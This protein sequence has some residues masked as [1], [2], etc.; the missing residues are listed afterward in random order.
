MAV[1]SYAVYLFHNSYYVLLDQWLSRYVYAGG[2]LKSAIFLSVGVLVLFVVAY[3]LQRA[4]DV[5][6]NPLFRGRVMGILRNTCQKH[7]PM[8]KTGEG[9]GRRRG[10]R[11][12]IPSPAGLFTPA[13]GHSRRLW[14]GSGHGRCRTPPR[15]RG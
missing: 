10:G 13:P 14:P 3:S 5:I 7:N 9:H 11:R 15:G 4:M 1:A 6:Q 2:Y 8:S 12:G